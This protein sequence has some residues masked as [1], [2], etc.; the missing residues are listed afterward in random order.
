MVKLVRA[1][2]YTIY[3]PVC[4]SSLGDFLF[5]VSSI[6]MPHGKCWSVWCD[7]RHFK[8]RRPGKEG[9][10]KKGSRG[11]SRSFIQQPDDANNRGKIDAWDNRKVGL[12]VG[13]E[14]EC[15]A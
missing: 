2:L 10:G 1:L 7:D 3:L 14:V 11:F 5:I 15:H 9:K 12:T 6:L 8:I 13:T 4:L